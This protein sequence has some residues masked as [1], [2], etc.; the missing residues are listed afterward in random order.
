MSKKLKNKIENV[1]ADMTAKERKNLT[2]RERNS[3]MRKAFNEKLSAEDV[4]YMAIRDHSENNGYQPS[5]VEIRDSTGYH[6][7]TI[8]RA[9]H[10]LV[11]MGFVDSQL[12]KSGRLLSRTLRPT[13]LAPPRVVKNCGLPNSMLRFIKGFELG[14]KRTIFGNPKEIVRRYSD[15]QEHFKFTMN[16]GSVRIQRIK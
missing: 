6:P 2:T 4:V 3:I 5:Q 15:V 14:T 16:K 1:F 12:T 7:N 8:S 10:N 13:D 11:S 9:I